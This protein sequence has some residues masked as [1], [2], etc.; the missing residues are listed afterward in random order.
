MTIFSDLSILPNSRFILPE[1]AMPFYEEELL[2]QFNEYLQ[3]TG[4]LSLFYHHSTRKITIL[5]SASVPEPLLQIITKVFLAITHQP[6]VQLILHRPQNTGDYTVSIKKLSQNHQYLAPSLQTSTF[7][8][9]S[10]GL[11]LPR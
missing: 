3:T 7:F 4:A 9:S 11:L 5:N 6:N 1:H 2:Y 10:L 8:Q